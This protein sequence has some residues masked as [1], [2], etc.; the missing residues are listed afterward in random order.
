L[1]AGLSEKRFQDEAKKT[2][3]AVFLNGFNSVFS[4]K[5]SHWKNNQIF[6]SAE[7]FLEE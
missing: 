6:P 3:T 2:T 4:G 7:E 1:I 5:E